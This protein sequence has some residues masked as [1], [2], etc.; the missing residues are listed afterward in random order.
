M[1]PKDYKKIPDIVYFK[2]KVKNPFKRFLLWITGKNKWKP[3]KIE[4]VDFFE[5]G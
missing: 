2:I 3:F 4:L 5:E 1:P